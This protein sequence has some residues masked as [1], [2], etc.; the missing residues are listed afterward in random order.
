MLSPLYTIGPCIITELNSSFSSFTILDQVGKKINENLEV[1]EKCGLWYNHSRSF[2][3][4]A[5]NASEEYW[6]GV[7]PVD[8]Q[9]TI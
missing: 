9:M 8:E 2:L 7:N 3:F 6:R 4:L 5:R 1:T